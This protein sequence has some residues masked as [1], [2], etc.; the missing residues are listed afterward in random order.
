MRV[1]VSTTGSNPVGPG[2]NPGGATNSIIMD[3]LRGIKGIDSIYLVDELTGL[4]PIDY[5]KAW[6]YT[7]PTQEQLDEIKRRMKEDTEAFEE[8]RNCLSHLL[9]DQQ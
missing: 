8:Q 2:S 7:R 3:K 9:L 1:T 5:K 4:Q 6:K